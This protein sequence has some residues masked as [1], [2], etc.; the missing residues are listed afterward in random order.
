MPGDEVLLNAMSV[1]VDVAEPENASARRRSCARS[2]TTL[3]FSWSLA[4]RTSA[5]SRSSAATPQRRLHEG[6]TVIIDPRTG[7]ASEKVERTGVEA[8]LL[9]EVPDVDYA[10]IGGLGPQIERIRDAIELPLRHPELY[11]EHD[12]AARRAACC[13]TALPVVERRSS[14]RRWRTR[15]ARPRARTVSYFLS[16]KGPEL[17]NKYVGETERYIRTI[18]ERAR[19]QGALRRARCHLL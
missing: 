14:R 5:S 18:F 17:L 6:D 2:S 13:C 12:A 4:A 8:L 16:V 15:L 10:S 7:F 19:A 1:V 9:E 11:V 3:A